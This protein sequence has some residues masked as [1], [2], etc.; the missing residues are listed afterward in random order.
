MMNGL[1]LSL[2]L[3]MVFLAAYTLGARRTAARL[4]ATSGPA[5][6]PASTISAEALAAL[7]SRLTPMLAITGHK[8]FGNVV[9]FT[10]HLKGETDEMF[11]RIREAFAGEPLTPRLLEGDEDD[12]RVIVLPAQAV[13]AAADRPKWALHWLLFVAT[14]ATTTWAG[15]PPRWREPAPGEGAMGSGTGRRAAA[16]GQPDM[17][18]PGR[19]VTFMLQGIHPVS[20]WEAAR[21]RKATRMAIASL[22]TL[23]LVLVGAI[24]FSH[25][26]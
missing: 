1:L 14:V 11:H 10:G 16:A 24:L 19:L 18:Q 2:I 17:C 8:A 15:L 12:V 26:K 4:R 3:V 9:Q 20:W 25:R 22:A 21:E 13:P 23:L 5:G 7:Q 6:E